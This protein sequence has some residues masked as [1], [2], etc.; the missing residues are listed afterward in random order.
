MQK[1]FDHGLFW[2]RRDLRTRDNVGLSAAI[3][4]CKQLSCMF[5]FDSLILNQLES[6]EDQRVD[7]IHRSLQ[8]LDS[9]LQQRNSKLIVRIGDP[10]VQI[11]WV[12]EALGIDAVFLNQDYEPYAKQ[13]DSFI[14][15]KLIDSDINV[16]AFKDQVIF[17]KNEVV[18][19]DGTPYRVFSPYKK[20]WLSHLSTQHVSDHSVKRFNFTPYNVLKKTIQPWRLQDLGFKKTFLLVE[21]GQEHAWRKLKAFHQ[22]IKHYKRDRD[23]PGLDNGTSGLSICLR[24]GTLSV[25]ACVRVAL[26]EQ[27]D[28]HM[29]WLNELIWRDFYHMILDQFPHVAKE[30]FQ[31]KYKNLKWPGE[32][33]LFEKWSHGQTGYPLIDAAMRCLNKTGW[34]HNRLRMVVAMFLTKDL[35]CH[36]KWGEHYFAKKLFD[37]DLAA[38]NGGWQ[39]SASTGVDAQPYFRVFNP[40]TQSKRFD[41]KGTFIRR[42][43]QE[44]SGFPDKYIHEPF[45]APLALQ[46]Q[47]GCIVGKHYPNPIVD[48]KVQ[49]LKAISLFKS[50]V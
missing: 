49:R 31:T 27:S 10:K 30:A 44:L 34:M 9:F 32:Q 5:V 46:K 41:A 14:Q 6:K 11:L 36:Y 26:Y 24:F 23:F 18:K 21:S 4:S 37:F 19:N 8:A 47:A 2:F 38:N 12:A 16:Q 29:T 1:K 39:W 42:Y 25:R 40:W 22:H 20:K 35:L 50:H 33:T 45:K 15:K 17:A 7:Y 28:G 48:H 43:C 3:K 13:R